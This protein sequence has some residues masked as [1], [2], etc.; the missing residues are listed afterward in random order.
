M[1][2]QPRTVI[3]RCPAC[4][5]GDQVVKFRGMFSCDVRLECPCG[6]AGPWRKWSPDERR[7]PWH[8]AAGGWS[9][10]FGEPQMTR[11]P[12]PVAMRVSRPPSEA[13]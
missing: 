12:P 1:G 9:A 2:Y 5:A 10:V 11:P 8:D 7:D 13:V 3:R 6:V 4:G